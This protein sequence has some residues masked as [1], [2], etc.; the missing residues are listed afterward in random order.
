MSRDAVA[1]AWVAVDADHVPDGEGRPLILFHDRDP[2]DWLPHAAH[3]VARG[4]RVVLPSFRDG[5]VADVLV[6]DALALLEHLGVTAYDLGGHGLGAQVVVRMLVQG[7]KPGRAVLVGAG[8]GAVSRPDRGIVPTSA[9]ELGRI[10]TPVLLLTDV[11]DGPALAEAL[12]GP[13]LVVPGIGSSQVVSAITGFFDANRTFPPP[14][15]RAHRP[16]DDAWPRGPLETPVGAV[17][18]HDGPVIR[19]HYGTHG[20]VDHHD[21]TG[22]DLGEL[23]ER[24]QRHFAARGEPVEW[25]TYAHESPDLPAHLLAAGFTPGWERSVLAAHEITVHEITADEI[26]VPETAGPE[27]SEVRPFSRED[28]PEV[29][30]LTADGPHRTPFADLEADFRVHEANV[31]VVVAGGRVVGVGW[32]EVQGDGVVVVGGL[33]GPLPQVP[34]EW[35]R[36]AEPESTFYA[37]ADGELRDV[38]R[39][40]GF[41]EVATARSYHWSPPNPPAATRPVVL[42]FDQPEYDEVWDRFRRRFRFRP[43][44]HR[45]PGIAEPPGSVTWQLDFDQA[46]EVQAV[47]VAG[48][49]AVV[50][51]EL[52]WLDWQHVG[53]RFDPHRVDGPGRPPW[54]GSVHPDGDYYLHVTGDVRLGT[55]GHPWEDTLC[56]FGESLVAQVEQPL[57]ALLGAPIRRSWNG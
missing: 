10:R 47:V 46:D 32:A 42:L 40:A 34:A 20:T 45:F 17:V 52:Y 53:Y 55:F 24:L 1:A 3:L 15:R 6:A 19:V 48:L 56:V 50:D 7:A 43:S 29:L 51:E 36:W 39:H 23:V 12:S 31:Q 13:H 28:L 16:A 30:R 2:D 41:R 8:L 27:G 18:E 11:D 38:L 21:L 37:E 44:T 14:P 57:T 22:I 35:A 5:A 25:K 26:T 49:R 9:E 33:T 4:H 54:P